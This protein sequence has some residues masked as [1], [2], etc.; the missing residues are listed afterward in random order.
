MLEGTGASADVVALGHV[1]IIHTSGAEIDKLI[2]ND[3]EFGLRFYRFLAIT[4]ANR[5]RAAN[6]V[7]RELN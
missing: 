7:V 3:P 4:I 2:K 6:K 5:L 1:A